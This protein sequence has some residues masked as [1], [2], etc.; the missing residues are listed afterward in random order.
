MYGTDDIILQQLIVVH[1]LGLENLVPADN[2]GSAAHVRVGLVSV[3]HLLDKD[4]L[5]HSLSLV[6]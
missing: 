1:R 3:E 6:V 5:F 2:K 4:S